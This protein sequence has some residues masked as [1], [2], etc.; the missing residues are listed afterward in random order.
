MQISF[1]QIRSDLKVSG[2]ERGHIMGVEGRYGASG[3]AASTTA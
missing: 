1:F 2:L 3:R